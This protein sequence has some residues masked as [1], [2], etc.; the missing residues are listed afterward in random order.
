MV[1][2]KQELIVKIVVSCSKKGSRENGQTSTK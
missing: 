2:G 1:L